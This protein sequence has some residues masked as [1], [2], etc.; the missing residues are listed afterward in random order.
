MLNRSRRQAY[1]Y[2]A[3]PLIFCTP[4]QEV[5]NHKKMKQNQEKLD[6]TIMYL[7]KYMQRLARETAMNRQKTEIAHH[8]TLY[9]LPYIYQHYY[10]YIYVHNRY[11]N[12]S[13]YLPTYIILLLCLE[14]LY[15]SNI[16]RLKLIINL[17]TDRCPKCNYEIR[18]LP[19]SNAYY[20]NTCVLCF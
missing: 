2:E 19:I 11:S 15:F 14:S 9:C 12:S 4:W 18:G 20:C 8:S 17:T 6:I 10:L 13:S 1:M 7:N 5:L 16:V 3:S